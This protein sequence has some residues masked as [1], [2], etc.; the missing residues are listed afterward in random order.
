[1]ELDVEEPIDPLVVKV[2]F[3]SARTGPDPPLRFF[4][5]I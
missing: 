5:T 3:L 2:E 4:F 1:M